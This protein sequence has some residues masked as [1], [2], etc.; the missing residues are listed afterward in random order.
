[1]DLSDF[2]VVARTTLMALDQPEPHALLSKMIQHFFGVTND[3]MKSGGRVV[4]MEANENP[5][6]K[7]SRQQLCW[8]SES[9]S[10]PGSHPTPAK[11]LHSHPIGFLARAEKKVVGMA[12]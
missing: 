2:C 11:F 9:H 4:V 7:I 10:L 3:Q 5:R 6:H 1:V 8:P 12:L